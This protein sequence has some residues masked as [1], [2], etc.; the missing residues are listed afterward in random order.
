[1]ERSE[2]FAMAE[3]SEPIVKE[4]ARSKPLDKYFGLKIASS[5]S[6]QKESVQERRKK[7]LVR[8]KHL[9]RVINLEQ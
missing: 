5:V 8:N 3:M 1:M 7:A 2:D 6:L 9:L 4:E